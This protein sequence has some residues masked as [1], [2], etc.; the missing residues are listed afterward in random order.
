MGDRKRFI[1]FDVLWFFV[2][3]FLTI[4]FWQFTCICD[5]IQVKHDLSSLSESKAAS[6]A[7]YILKHSGNLDA[8]MIQ[9]NSREIPVDMSGLWISRKFESACARVSCS[10]KTRRR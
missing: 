1:W 4:S 10:T 2:L 5:R 6:A 8:L 7:S 3:R 9:K